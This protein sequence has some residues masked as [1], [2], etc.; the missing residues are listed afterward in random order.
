MEDVLLACIESPH[1]SRV[2]VGSTV[3]DFMS[4]MCRPHMTRNNPSICRCSCA[5]QNFRDNPCCSWQHGGCVT[6]ANV[7]T[8]ATSGGKAAEAHARAFPVPL[9]RLRKLS[10]NKDVGEAAVEAGGAEGGFRGVKAVIE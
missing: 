10:A 9:K 8:A 1:V 3:G 5:S 4:D 2:P 6:N 7:P